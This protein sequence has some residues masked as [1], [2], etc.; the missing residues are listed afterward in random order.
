MQMTLPA[1]KP[2]EFAQE[3]E[4]DRSC[5]D[6]AGIREICC[7]DP[8]SQNEVIRPMKPPDCNAEGTA[9]TLIRT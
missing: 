7:R 3:H 2:A 9:P 4:K 6:E 1:K 8:V 5:D